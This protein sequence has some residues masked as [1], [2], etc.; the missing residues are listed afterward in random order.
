MKRQGASVVELLLARTASI[1][2]AVWGWILTFVLCVSPYY[3]LADHQ[4]SQANSGWVF[5]GFLI[6]AYLAARLVALRLC[7]W[8]NRATDAALAERMM[9]VARERA[10][11]KF[12]RRY[13]E[14]TRYLPNEY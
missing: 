11:K 1:G 13:P 5:A 2:V 10:R 9:T 8:H 7:R 3:W 14:L 4:Y 6:F 12:E